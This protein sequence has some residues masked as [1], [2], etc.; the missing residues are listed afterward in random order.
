[1]S[2]R[3][4]VL[5]ADPVETDVESITHDGRGIARVAGKQVFID[6]ALPGERVAFRCRACH[7]RF[8]AGMVSEVLRP[9]PERVIPRCPHAGMCG[10][11]SLQHLSPT[12]QIRLK[13]ER[14]LEHLRHPLGIPLGAICSRPCSAPHGATGA[15]PGWR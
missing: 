9:A 7:G 10:G 4:R 3:R 5:P 6:G 13:Q 11:C 12:A 2:R 8:D 1:M 14:L 15:R